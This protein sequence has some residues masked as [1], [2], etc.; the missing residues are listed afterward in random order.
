MVAVVTVPMKQPLSPSQQ[1]MQR[2]LS[3]K[4]HSN[5]MSATSLMIKHT[6]N[7][8]IFNDDRDDAWGDPQYNSCGNM[9]R[10]FLQCNPGLLAV[11]T[12]LVHGVAGLGGVLGVIPAVQLHDAWLACVYLVTFCVTSTFTMGGFAA[13]YGSLSQ[14]LAGGDGKKGG[15]RVFMVEMGSALLSIAVGLVWLTLLT[16]GKLDNV[17]S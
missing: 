10:R 7:R 11:A 14:W 4:P 9:G 12:G 1:Q 2:Q 8:P 16:L 15:S 17:F 3:T 13:F 5:L 6:Q